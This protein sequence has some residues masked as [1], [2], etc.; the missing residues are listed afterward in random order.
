MRT[1]AR[2]VELALGTAVLL[3]LATNAAWHVKHGRWFDAF[4]LC[5][6]AALLAGVA[7]L[8][9][10]ALLATVAFVW[11]VPGTLC[12]GIEASLL[13]STFGWP[14]Y[15]L[16][17]AGAV[18]AVFAVW[19]LGAH[20]AGYLGALLLL[21]LLLLLSRFLPEGANVN[22][23]FGPREGWRVFQWLPFGHWLS[24]AILGALLSFAMNQLAL[25]LTYR[26]SHVLDPPP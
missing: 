10:Q 1:R 9:R 12:W 5:N 18:G 3:A 23:A 17:L 11:L 13:G 8:L 4:W 16:H 21:A 2:L 20:R 6:A 26:R 24:L 7:L 14:S 25:A 22:C 19:R 15:A